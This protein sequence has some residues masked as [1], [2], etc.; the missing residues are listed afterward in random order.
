MLI[1]VSTGE[2][3]DKISILVIKNEKITDPVKLGHVQKELSSLIDDFPAEILIDKLYTELCGTNLLLW[4]IED[5]I[6]EKERLGEFDS[7]FIQLAREVYITNDK[8]AA[9]KKE[10]NIKYGSDI[11][12]EKSYKPY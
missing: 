6:R 8:R 11:I 5:S 9:L 1:D 4:Y 10:I 3:A 7:E 2:V 12:E